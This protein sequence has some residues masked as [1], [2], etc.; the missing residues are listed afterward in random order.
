M[1]ALIVGAP[2]AGSFVM[3]KTTFSP[4]CATGDDGET[5]RARERGRDDEASRRP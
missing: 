1:W 2:P 5:D 3:A 4:F